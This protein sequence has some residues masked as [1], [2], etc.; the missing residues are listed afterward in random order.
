KSEN[1]AF[2]HHTTMQAGRRRRGNGVSRPADS[3]SRQSPDPGRETRESPAP[4][5][6]K[7]VNVRPRENPAS[8]LRSPHESFAQRCRPVRSPPSA[9]FANHILGRAAAHPTQPR[10][11]APQPGREYGSLRAPTGEDGQGEP[12]T[13]KT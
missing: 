7:T 12:A 1:F 8:T 9:C 6:E 2:V 13:N 3:Q 5:R 4:Q 10:T 11:K